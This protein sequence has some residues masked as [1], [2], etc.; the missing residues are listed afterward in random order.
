MFNDCKQTQCET[1]E[2]FIAK[3]RKLADT[4][5]FGELREELIRDRLVIGTKDSSAQARMLR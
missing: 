5:E 3:L 4:C 2:Q 1:A